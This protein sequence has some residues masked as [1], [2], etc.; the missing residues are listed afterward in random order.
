MRRIIAVMVLAVVMLDASRLSD[1]M[2]RYKRAPESQ[3]Y[4]I[5]NQIKQEIARLN[6][7]R[8][9]AAI[10]QLRAVNNSIQSRKKDRHRRKG[11]RSRGSSSAMAIL[12]GQNGV[13]V[14]TRTP[15]RASGSH[16][17]SGQTG[18]GGGVSGSVGGSVGGVSG[19]VSG[20]IGGMSGGISGG[21]GGMSGGISGSTGG[22]S[23]GH[24]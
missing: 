23:G 12:N 5:M 16:S 13:T 20:G 8:Q 11:H 18:S 2:A 19:G 3:R 24:K 6:R 4:R 17:V 1:L 7:K 22:M 9:H 15:G 10:R 14:S 21:I